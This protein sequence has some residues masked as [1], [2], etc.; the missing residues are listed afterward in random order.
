MS[1]INAI[2]LKQLRALL[3]V[4]EHGSITLAAEALNLTIPAVSMQIKLL[5]QNAGAK[6]LDRNSDGNTILTLQGQQVLTA[7]ERVESALSHCFQNI[8]SINK[9]KIGL[10]RLG[11]VSTGK[12]FAPS[13][14]ALA[15]KQLPDVE[16]KL[17]IGNRQQVIAGLEDHSLDIV[18][19]GR[20]PRQPLV[21]ADALG[22]HPH[23]LI[24]SPEHKLA[25]KTKIEADDI[26][27][28]TLILRE[29]GS[30]TRILAERF[31]DQIGEGKLF[32]SIEFNSNV[33]IKTAVIAN[34]GIALISA[35]T[36]SDAL[37][38]GKLVAL[39]FP[40][41]PII[42]LW[43][44]V[45]AIGVELSP[46]AQRVQRFVIENSQAFLPEIRKQ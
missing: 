23:V 15:K 36:V 45:H 41:L 6:L 17:E 33:T 35:H 39:D 30:G 9:G 20:P 11:V 38:D 26:L 44:L 19:M 5:S 34:L 32:E 2:T 46:V 43:F 40:G 14:L 18:I 3:A 28:E 16:I 22:E 37:A 21:D 29:R 31:L 27:N 12:F 8:E 10:V 25:Q 7:I 4:H 42:R 1:H 13:I 24:A